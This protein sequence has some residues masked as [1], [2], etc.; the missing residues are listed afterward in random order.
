MNMKC[1]KLLLDI[2]LQKKNSKDNIN[3]SSQHK[4]I[5]SGLVQL[6]QACSSRAETS[7][8]TRLQ[9]FPRNAARKSHTG[10]GTQDSDQQQ[11]SSTCFPSCFFLFVYRFSTF[12][13]NFYVSKPVLVLP[14]SKLTKARRVRS[15]CVKSLSCSYFVT[16]YFLSLSQNVLDLMSE[17]ISVMSCGFKR[18]GNHTTTK[19]QNT[20]TLANT[21]SIGYY[22][23]VQ[24]LKPKSGNGLT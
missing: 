19:A 7:P 13:T 22:L 10:T 12:S 2:L 9:T 15:Y 21:Y 18:C 20:P 8:H 16:N 3:T 14:D 23:C 1:K 5:H 6:M 24:Y 4:R 11:I 17:S